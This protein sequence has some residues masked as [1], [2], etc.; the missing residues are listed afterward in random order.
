M[1]TEIERLSAET[2]DKLAGQLG[3]SPEELRA[4]DTEW[5]EKIA[6]GVIVKVKVGRWRA[7]RKLTYRNLGINAPRGKAKT[8]IDSLIRLGHVLLLPDKTRKK[9]ESLEI[10]SR[11]AGKRHGSESPWGWY[12]SAEKFAD[13][14]SEL[15]KIRA[16][17]LG[18][19]DEISTKEGWAELKRQIADQSR[20]AARAAYK[21]ASEITKAD[22]TTIDTDEDAFV[23]RYVR[24]ILRMLPARDYVRD[25]FYLDVDYSYAPLLSQL[26][27]ERLKLE[28]IRHQREIMATSG[29]KAAAEALEAEASAVAEQTAQLEM[30]R[31]IATNAATRKSELIDQFLVGYARKLHGL[32]NESAE[33]M[34]R[35]TRKNAKVHPRSITQL[36]NLIKTANQLTA[37]GMEIPDVEAMLDRMSDT[38]QDIKTGNASV[39]TIDKTL[40]AVAVVSRN[41]LL[42]LGENPR[43]SRVEDLPEVPTLDAVA[44]A[45]RTLQGPDAEIEFEFPE[46]S[47]ARRRPADVEQFE[48]VAV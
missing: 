30:H 1:M 10:R 22:G 27:S 18:I 34:L 39:T 11:Q 48:A 16:E 13:C 9:L 25:S 4:R 33:A 37:F 26:E 20:A 15:E 5:L 29:R 40:E 14:N 3:I 44:A 31:A 45:R 46:M 21:R 17:Y 36:E 12:V 41:G 35:T 43:S 23:E 24:S 2:R 6:Q 38:L 7:T 42:E 28:E 47:P 19:G 32:F 8:E